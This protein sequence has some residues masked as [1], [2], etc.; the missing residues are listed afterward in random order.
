[1]KFD[2]TKKCVHFSV[3]E[4]PPENFDIIFQKNI[5]NIYV[6]TETF[7][8]KNCSVENSLLQNR[9]CFSKKMS[10]NWST[11]L[12]KSRKLKVFNSSPRRKISCIFTLIVQNSIYRVRNVCRKMDQFWAEETPKRHP[13]CSAPQ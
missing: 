4:N 6:C 7:R 9:S 13:V 12:S 10:K 1:M 5:L 11:F 2:V 8:Q 3:E